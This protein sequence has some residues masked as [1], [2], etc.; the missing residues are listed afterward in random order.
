MNK[1]IQ[2][3][4]PIRVYHHYD[5]ARLA[6]DGVL[7]ELPQRWNASKMSIASLALQRDLEKTKSL[8]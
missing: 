5:D 1:S 6:P 4:V 7:P 2:F 3:E 8:T